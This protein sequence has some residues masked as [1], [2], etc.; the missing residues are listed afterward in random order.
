[1]TCQQNLAP[2]IAAEAFRA[3]VPVAIALAVAQHET[4]MCHWWPDGSVKVG[5]AGEIG[6]FQVEP[7]TAPGVDLT[8][9]DANI[10]AGVGYL[11]QMY[12]EFGDW[13][14]T[15][16]AYNWGP[17]KVQKALLSGAPFPAAVN[18]YVAAVLG[19]SSVNALQM[20]A[21]QSEPPNL[22]VSYSGSSSV[23][24]WSLG[25]AGGLVLLTLLD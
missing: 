4:G 18:N 19:S 25:I 3:G 6:V 23:M 9:P 13:M 17:G 14:T 5:A 16:A 2:L 15:V 8:D 12:A 11:A 20:V 7:A 21:T 22:P 10:Q 24:K 1:M